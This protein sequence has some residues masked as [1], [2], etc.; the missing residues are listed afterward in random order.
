MKSFPLGPEEVH[1]LDRYGLFVIAT[2]HYIGFNFQPGEVILQEGLPMQYL[3]IIVSGNAKVCVSS[4]DGKEFT[5]T[6]YVSE[7]ILGDIELM[8]QSYISSTHVTAITDFNCIA[9]PYQQYANELRSNVTFLNMIGYELSN[10]LLNSTQNCK[11]NALLS[12][13]DRLCE[14]ILT[15]STYGIFRE[16]LTEVSS[17]IG[18]SYRHMFR[19]LKHLCDEHVLEKTPQGYKILKVDYLCHKVL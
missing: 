13:E 7:G 11:N 12:G 15:H 16:T 10:K 1:L 6:H 2:D 3:Y 19:I 8:T 14:Y 4:P 18:I 17:S 9:I 5:L